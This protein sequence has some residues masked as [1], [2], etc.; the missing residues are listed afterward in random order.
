MEQK[1]ATAEKVS[2]AISKFS[3]AFP[4]ASLSDFSS[5]VSLCSGKDLEDYSVV[6][7]KDSNLC[8]SN[9]NGQVELTEEGKR[10]QFSMGFQTKILNKRRIEGLEADTIMTEMLANLETL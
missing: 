7:L 9:E 1:E 3:N 4:D 5:F 8:F 6:G 10:L 2:D